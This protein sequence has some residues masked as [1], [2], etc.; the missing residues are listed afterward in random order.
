M[1][2]KRRLYACVLFAAALSACAT[3][4]K[5]RIQPSARSQ[6]PMREWSKLSHQEKTGAIAAAIDLKRQNGTQISLPPDYYVT[7]IDKL[8]QTY[9]NTG[10]EER[11]DTSVG[12][13]FRTI[14]VMEGDWGD[15]EGRVSQAKRLFGPEIF[16][17]FKTREPA[18]YQHL[19]DL[20]KQDASP[21]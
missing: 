3:E 8:H 13:T 7:E 11:L 14:A 20:D 15:G 2:G 1:P 12:I 17:E 16:E 18:K 4:H 5:I 10:N 6:F 9:V 19:V 21:R